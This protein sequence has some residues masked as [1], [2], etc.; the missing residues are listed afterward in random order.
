[1]SIKN[2]IF[3]VDGV[4]VN[5]DTAFVHFLQ[6][7]PEYKNIREEEL[8]KFKTDTPQGY[9]IP[10]A[11]AK[12]KSFKDSEFYM[13]RPLFPGVIETLREL[14]SRGFKLFTLSA[15]RSPGEKLKMLRELFG[16]LFDYEF[17]LEET[18][19]GPLQNMLDK[20]NLKANETLFIDDSNTF[21]REAK[22]VSINIARSEIIYYSPLA[23]DL[24]G[25][26]VIRKFSDILG[27]VE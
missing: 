15:T 23:D 3:D 11:E 12:R 10:L 22:G 14:K 4:L 24:A 21:L 20:Y 26:P 17:A 5:R 1:M 19:A 9:D 16:D 8:Y 25:T 7:F 18:K 2:I 27:L 6:Q 13:Q